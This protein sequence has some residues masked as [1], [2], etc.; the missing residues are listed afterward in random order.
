MESQ[1]QVTHTILPRFYLKDMYNITDEF[2]LFYQALSSR[3]MELKRKKCAGGKNKGYF[4]LCSFLLI[5]QV[6]FYEL[7]YVVNM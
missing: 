6:H 2:D 1:I 5:L 4:I 3:T 7:Q